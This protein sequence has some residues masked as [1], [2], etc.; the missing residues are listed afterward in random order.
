MT[1]FDYKMFSD[2]SIIIR[3]NV[4]FAYKNEELKKEI[5][6]LETYYKECLTQ[7][8]VKSWFEVYGDEKS[9]YSIYI[10]EDKK[11]QILEF[12]GFEPKVLKS[13]YEEAK[14]EENE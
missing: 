5:G 4:E 9:G 12:L 1:E 6:E 7:K 8:D 10:A 2:M 13:I 14:G 3:E 11:A